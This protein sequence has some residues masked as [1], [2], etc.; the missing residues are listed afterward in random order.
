MTIIKPP[1]GP[2]QTPAT[3]SE[4]PTRERNPSEISQIVERYLSHINLLAAGEQ[5]RMYNF[6]RETVALSLTDD[7]TRIAELFEYIDRSEQGAD[8]DLRFLT[9]TRQKILP[10]EYFEQPI[11]RAVAMKLTRPLPEWKP[12]VERVYSSGAPTLLPGGAEVVATSPE[13]HANSAKAF[14]ELSL[15]ERWT[16]RSPNFTLRLQMPLAD[17]IAYEQRLQYPL[18]SSILRPA[19][20]FSVMPERLADLLADSVDL[21]VRKS[22]GDISGDH[23]L[24]L[25]RAMVLQWLDGG[26]WVEGVRNQRG[27]YQDSLRNRSY[28]YGPGLVAGAIAMLS[29]DHL[30]NAM[31]LHSADQRHERFFLAAF[32]GYEANRMTLAFQEVLNNRLRGA[33][34]DFG[35]WRIGRMNQKWWTELS[36]EARESLPKALA[37]S[38]F[39]H[40]SFHGTPLQVSWGIL[41]SGLRLPFRTLAGMGPGLV[42][43]ALADA[44]T[45]PFLEPDSAARRWIQTGAFFAPDLSRILL[46]SHAGFYST[47]LVRGLSG[48]FAAGMAVDLGYHGLMRYLHGDRASFELAI[49]ARAA[50]LKRQAEGS[51]LGALSTVLGW[52]APETRNRLDSDPRYRVQAREEYHRQ[53]AWLAEESRW[54]LSR[55][56]NLMMEKIS[57]TPLE[58]CIEEYLI[59]KVSNDPQLQDAPV[60]EWAEIIRRQFRGHRLSE[61]QAT[62]HLEQ[63]RLKNLQKNIS[64]AIQMEENFNQRFFASLFNQDGTWKPDGDPRMLFYV[65]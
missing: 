19:L 61:A 56:R 38:W 37:A 53:T 22:A 9:E 63:I 29:A 43:A 2:P 11:P 45:S 39:R 28:Q 6:L 31:D 14:T 7:P 1:N 65:A 44:V 23:R 5:P 55:H 58:T 4:P 60:S 50:E 48:L 49:G 10:L 32:L 20:P 52:I 46:G 34:F 18:P 27:I 8:T 16:R 64:V 13:G 33:A 15:L 62:H 26:S 21:A 40:F 57:L 17:R 42:T 36:L 59:Y 12:P 30:S 35:R 25:P 51:P 3:G 41:R 47:R 54:A 24:Q